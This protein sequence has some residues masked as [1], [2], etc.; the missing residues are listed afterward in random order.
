VR[1][2]NTV[3][4]CW[5]FLPL[6]SPV[7]WVSLTTT[8]GRHIEMQVLEASTISFGTGI[9]KPKEAKRIILLL[10]VACVL[11]SAILAVL[12]KK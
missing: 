6:N 12:K 9:S 10:H 1:D 8:A 3:A 4:S 11:F 5:I 2:S 7:F